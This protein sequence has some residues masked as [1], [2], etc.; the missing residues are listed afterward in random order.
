M[1]RIVVNCGV[2]PVQQGG[3]ED[4]I[5]TFGKHAGKLL[6]DPEVHWSYLAW[7]YAWLELCRLPENLMPVLELVW[8]WGEMKFEAAQESGEHDEYR[9]KSFDDAL[10]DAR[11]GMDEQ[12]KDN[13]GYQQTGW[14]LTWW[15]DDERDK[16]ETITVAEKRRREREAARER[17]AAMVGEAVAD[18]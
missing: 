12:I 16:W 11:L 3:V 5:I 10:D 8:Y 7:A 13:E 6:S 15:H 14:Q 2:V 4:G 18:G 17:A 1:A 9:E